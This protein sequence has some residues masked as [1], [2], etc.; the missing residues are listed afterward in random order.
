MGSVILL[1][2][3]SDV[4]L[5]PTGF[6]K[7]TNLNY[8]PYTLIRGHF[9]SFLEFA[10]VGLNPSQ[11]YVEHNGWVVL[12]QLTNILPNCWNVSIWQTG[13]AA[14]S[15][16]TWGWSATSSS[17]G[18]W[19]SSPRSKATKNRLAANEP[20]GNG[21]MDSP[22]ACWAG[23]NSRHRHCRVAIFWWF[24]SLSGLRW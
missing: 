18:R 9:I 12:N 17:S 16:T 13:A 3:P 22:L 4:F 15:W 21:V 11:I 2:L 5:W 24:F 7:L 19:T 23:F 1:Q 8:S 20:E 14:R 10:I 6:K